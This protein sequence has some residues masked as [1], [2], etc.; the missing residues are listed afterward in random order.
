MTSTSESWVV[1]FVQA[2]AY[3]AAAG[4]IRIS[5]MKVTLDQPPNRRD[6]RPQRQLVDDLVSP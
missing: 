4:M 6:V 5:S 2:L 1:V 3:V